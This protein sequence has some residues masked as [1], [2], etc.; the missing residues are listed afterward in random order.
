M[1]QIIVFLQESWDL[2]GWSKSAEVKITAEDK[3]LRFFVS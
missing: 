2:L 3:E 1:S